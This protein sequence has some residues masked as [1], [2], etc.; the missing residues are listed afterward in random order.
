MIEKKEFTEK[1]EL[2]MRVKKRKND[3][4]GRN[5]SEEKKKRNNAKRKRNFGRK[6]EIVEILLRCEQA[7]DRLHTGEFRQCEC[8]GRAKKFFL[9]VPDCL[10]VTVPTY[11]H[12]F[13]PSPQ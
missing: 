11:V 13:S 9:C 12:K 2:K 5:K 7:E 4:Q 10:C 8:G 6:K 1:F 3:A